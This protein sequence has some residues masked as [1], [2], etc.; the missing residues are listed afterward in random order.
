MIRRRP[1]RRR[2]SRARRRTRPHPSRYRHVPRPT[3]DGTAR[4]HATSRRPIDARPSRDRRSPATSAAAVGDHRPARPRSGGRR[5]RR[6]CRPGD[7]R[8]HRRASPRR[9]AGR[10]DAPMSTPMTSP[11]RGPHPRSGRCR[12]LGG[13]RA[14]AEPA[15][16]GIEPGRRRARSPRGVGDG[17]CRGCRGG[18]RRSTSPPTA[19]STAVDEDGHLRRHGDADRVGEPDRRGSGVNGAAGCGHDC[20]GI[21]A[22]LERAAR[23]RSPASSRPRRRRRRAVGGHRSNSSSASSVPTPALCRLWVSLTDTTYCRW[24]E[25]GGEGSFGAAPVEHQPPPDRRRPRRRGRPSRRH[26]ASASAIAGTRSGRT[27]LV[28]SRSRTPAAHERFEDRRLGVGARSA[29]RPG[30]PSRRLT[31]RSATSGGKASRRRTRV[32]VSRFR[33]AHRATR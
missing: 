22:V 17:E 23:S 24:V 14:A 27:K 21:D 10:V 13:E 2:T 16:A 28:S 31:S 30:S 29:L 5:D 20:G 26:S 4:H 15:D 19:S 8:R 1:C 3:P 18:A 32:H 11:A 6:G 7:R 12:W 33:D 25:P 9:R